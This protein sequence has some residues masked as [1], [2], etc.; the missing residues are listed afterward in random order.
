MMKSIINDM[1]GVRA[2]IN[3]VSFQLINHKKIRL[4]KNCKKFLASIERLS[5]HTEYTVAMSLP[6]LDKSY[7][8][9]VLS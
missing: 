7:P 4:P 8:V 2:N 5:E 3:N 9:F 6:N 1:T